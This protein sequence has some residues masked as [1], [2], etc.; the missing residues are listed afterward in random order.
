MKKEQIAFLVV[1]L[2]LG[3][4]GYS[5]LSGGTSGKPKIA[6]RVDAG[7]P[8]TLGGA[9]VD[10]GVGLYRRVG[11][12]GGRSRHPTPRA[13]EARK[14]NKLGGAKKIILSTYETSGEKVT[15]AADP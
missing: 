3:W 2:L 1:V 14:R 15:T 5:A 9:A 8:R 6:V 7:V 12:G 13:G 10:P 4:L 11:D